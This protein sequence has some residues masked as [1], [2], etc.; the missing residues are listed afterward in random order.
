M[1]KIYLFLIFFQVF[2]TVFSQ[3][4]GLENIFSLYRNTISDIRPTN[5]PLYP[6]CSKYSEYSF[7][8]FGF[9]KGMTLTTDRLMRCG[10]ELN[11]YP[12]LEI[13]NEIKFLDY[14]YINLIDTLSKK[15]NEEQYLFRNFKEKNPLEIEFFLHL[16]N[17][18]DYKDAILEYKRIKFYNSEIIN[19]TFEYNYI[20]SLF[21]LGKYEDVIFSIQKSIFSNE[22]L[23]KIKLAESY[24]KL[25][26]Y[27]M[28]LT[29]IEDLEINKSVE[30]RSLIYTNIGDLISAEKNLNSIDKD[31]IFYE[32]VEHNKKIISDLKKVKLKSKKIAGILSVIPGG[33]YLYSGQKA[34]AIT[35]LFLNTAFCYATITS[36][37]SGNYGIA[38]LTGIFGSA[39]YIG[40]ILGG[41]K[42]A[43]RHNTYKKNY[44]LEKMKYSFNN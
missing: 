30:L 26:D 24:F 21:A 33:G 27:G 20:R 28:A 14:N 39:F 16:V 13:N 38:G 17:E 6:S 2:S 34:T 22:I 3:E 36:I 43:E 19:L 18:G 29:S 12:S 10:H 9:F 4:I 5:C 1:K 40:N 41:I 25:S 32:Y 8:K 42:S 7:K 37:K 35:S 44:Y 11:L 23:L 31:Y 15:N